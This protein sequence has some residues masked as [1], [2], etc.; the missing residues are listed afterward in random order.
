MKMP[1]LC[2]APTEA[3]YITRLVVGMQNSLN[4][5]D[6]QPTNK[7]LEDWAIFIHESM[8]KSSRNYHS[9]QHVFDLAQDESDPLL[10]LSAFF[11][12]C[13]Y[14]QVDG[15][16]SDFQA[17][18]LEGVINKEGKEEE[19]CLTTDTSDTLLCIVES[20]FG[21]EPGQIVKTGLN[22]FLSAV[23]AVRKLEPVLNVANLAQIA[24]CIEA[25]IPFRATN[26]ETPST[27]EILFERMVKANDKYK[28]GMNNEDLVKAVQRAARL[29]NLD[30]ANFGSTNRAWF[31]DNTW[32]LLPETNESL[33]DQYL[34]SVA[35]F[36]KAIY[37]MYGFFCFL[38]PN[39][40]FVSFRG[41]PPTEELAIM[42]REATRNMA[43]GKKYVRAKVLSM[44]VL[45]AF[46]VLTGGDCP[47]SLLIGDLCTRKHETHCM[48]ETATLPQPPLKLVKEHC[49]V[50]VYNILWKGRTQETSF[51][52]RQSPLAAYLYGWMGDEAVEEL[53]R[54]RQ[55][56]PM[57]EADAK[58][59]LENMPKVLVKRIGENMTDIAVSRADEIRS[60]LNDLPEQSCIGLEGA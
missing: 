5:L 52:I 39:V 8:S 34:Y 11:H 60:V 48:V 56:C 21:F 35:E 15:G 12:D 36:Q 55:V 37:N 7:Q 41:V 3:A 42:T 19:L 38:N 47:L 27:M 24:C 46:T 30:V 17:A 31:L 51:D 57:T 4:A 53:L 22:E 50:D 43:V 20:I 16:L 26:N 28:L 14:Y 18:V 44:S 58:D 33:R 6:A 45:M 40:I 2:L 23:V 54:D 10:V 29:S 49:D 1:R 25:T 59:L 32:S 13:I 9:V